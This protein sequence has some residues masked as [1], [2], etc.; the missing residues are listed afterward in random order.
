M[1]SEAFI[2]I[3]MKGFG[4]AV[5]G[6]L[7]LWAIKSMIKVKTDLPKAPEG[8]ITL[9]T[10]IS[11]CER[12]RS[13]CINQLNGKLSGMEKILGNRLESGERLFDDHTKRLRELEKDLTK[14]SINLKNFEDNLCTKITA[15]V[16]QALKDHYGE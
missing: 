12:N 3:A 4:I 8:I 13:T 1:G 10:L 6:G 9:Q 5:F 16:Q 2:D 14:V 11:H 7:A 15:V